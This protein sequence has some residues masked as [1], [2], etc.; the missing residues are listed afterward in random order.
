LTQLVR[1]RGK[2]HVESVSI[3]VHDTT[4]A[5]RPS[6]SRSEVLKDLI[7]D[8][9]HPEVRSPRHYISAVGTAREAR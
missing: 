2:D 4:V 1:E 5:S 6:I 8:A 7:R 3:D 9:V